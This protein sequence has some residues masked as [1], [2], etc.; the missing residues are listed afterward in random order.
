MGLESCRQC[1]AKTH[2]T[3]ACT[4]PNPLAY[5]KPGTRSR[6][7][8]REAMLRFYESGFDKHCR[9]PLSDQE[10]LT[11]FL[12]G[13][14]P[15]TFM[16]RADLWVIQEGRCFYCNVAMTWGEGLPLKGNSATLDHVIPV[17]R[18]G[19]GTTKV[20]SCAVGF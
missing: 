7:Q 12:A 19:A 2:F 16:R 4:A 17:S 3:D 20:Y 6:D 9:N 14:I 13:L 15:S 10:I 11:L 5:T 18:N 8:F 1:G